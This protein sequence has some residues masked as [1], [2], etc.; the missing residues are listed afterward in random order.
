MVDKAT[1][2]LAEDAVRPPTPQPLWPRLPLGAVVA[3]TSASVA[4]PEETPRV[5]WF[6][7]RN[8]P[9][10][11]LNRRVNHLFFSLEFLNRIL[12]R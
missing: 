1:M 7:F 8:V 10:N 3:L 6:M 2:L 9:V 5:R 11:V 12:H 4:D